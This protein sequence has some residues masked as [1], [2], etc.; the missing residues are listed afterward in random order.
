MKPTDRSEQMRRLLARRESERLTYRAAAALEPGVTVNQLFWW[1]RKLFGRVASS[2]STSA[3]AAPK[4]QRFVQVI[5]EPA[6]TSGLEIV[7]H[8]ERRVLVGAEFDEALLMRV[9]SAL[10]RC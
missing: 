5:E 9:V 8:N 3:P 4:R 10:E 1:R 7:L 6:R 2:S